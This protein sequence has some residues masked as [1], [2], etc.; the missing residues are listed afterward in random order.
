MR[1]AIFGSL[2]AITE[3]YHSPNRQHVNTYVDGAVHYAVSELLR[4]GQSVVCDAH[5]N[6]RSDR[7]AFEKIASE[8][9]AQ[10][11]LVRIVTPI[12][13]A[14]RRGQSRTVTADQR[15]LSEDDMREVID[16]H[17]ANT[18]EPSDSEHV[19]EVNGEIPFE[20][21]FTIFQE[22]LEVISKQ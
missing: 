15:Q 19:I 17:T 22:R 5:H 18:D 1:L 16:R 14:M 12:E 20:E 9:D 10:V 4:Q 3:V 13:L 21:Q 11:I 8:Y 2:E 6:R 7:E